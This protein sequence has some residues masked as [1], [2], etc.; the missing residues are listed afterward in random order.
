MSAR[1]KINPSKAS[2]V[3][4]IAVGIASM[5]LW[6]AAA[7]ELGLGGPVVLGAGAAVSVAVA[8]WTPLAD[9]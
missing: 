8:V 7:H 1:V 9:L 3:G 2:L 4:G 5:V 6:A